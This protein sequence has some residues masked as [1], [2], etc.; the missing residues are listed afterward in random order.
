ML[1]RSKGIKVHIETS[2]TADCNYLQLYNFGVWITVS[3]K[4]G[5][6]LMA[7]QYADEVKLLVDKHF[8]LE[9]ADEL[10]DGFRRTVFIQPINEEKEIVRE[11]VLRCLEIQKLRPEWRLS[12][13]LH[14]IL[15][16]R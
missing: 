5:T 9:K 13:Q 10:L 11:N 7:I 2:G 8:D 4:K 14:K 15:N 1:F 6:R 3:P 16:V 12:L